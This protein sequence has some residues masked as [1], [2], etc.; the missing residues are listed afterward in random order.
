M[1]RLSNI[2]VFEAK[3]RVLKGDDYKVL[4]EVAGVSV[5][6]D[7]KHELEINEHDLEDVR[8]AIAVDVDDGRRVMEKIDPP[9]GWDLTNQLVVILEYLDLEPEELHL[10]NDG[11]REFLLPVTFDFTG[12]EYHLDYER[13]KDALIEDNE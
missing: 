9:T 3:L 7:P 10:L 13:M 8:V 2:K 4:G 12:E 5:E 1:D 6:T 11:S